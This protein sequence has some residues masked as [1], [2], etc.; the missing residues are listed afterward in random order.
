MSSQRAA[1]LPVLL[2]ASTC[3]LGGVTTTVVDIPTR[4]VN[5]RFLYVHPDAPKANIVDLFGGTG[6]AGEFRMTDRSAIPPPTAIPSL[7]ICRPSPIMA[8]RSRWSTPPPTGRARNYP[9][10]LEVINYL[11]AHDNVPTWVIGGDLSTKGAAN[12]VG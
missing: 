3:A 6:C 9:D 2:L 5:Q 4:G 12:I 11:H 8:T 10:V 1:L 7:A